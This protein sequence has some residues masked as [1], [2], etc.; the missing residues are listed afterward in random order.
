MILTLCGSSRF[1]DSFH[2]YNIHL[3]LAGHVV[4]SMALTQKG[5][6]IP[7]AAEKQVLDLVHFAKIDVSD[8][9]FVIDRP[10]GL[11]GNQAEQSYIGFS[12]GNEMRYAAI[13]GK[14]I[15]QASRHNARSL[16]FSIRPSRD[17]FAS[18]FSD[19]MKGNDWKS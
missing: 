8:G 5:D 1:L 3:S 18:G 13:R 16:L 12:T 17:F 4:F 2:K 6:W 14:E 11:V 10:F 7:N 19:E 15:F 9:I